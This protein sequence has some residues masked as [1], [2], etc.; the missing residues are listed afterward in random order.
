MPAAGRRFPAAGQKIAALPPFTPAAAQEPNPRRQARRS[1]VP[2]RPLR[3]GNGTLPEETMARTPKQTELDRRRFLK[4]VAIGGAAVGFAGS[5]E[6][7]M[8]PT[9]APNEP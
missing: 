4:G 1:A 5:A 3:A 9:A 8:P 2:G 6:A 7:Q